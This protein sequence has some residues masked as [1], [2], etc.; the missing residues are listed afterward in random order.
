MGTAVV[1][2]VAASF[3]GAAGGYTAAYLTIGG[4]AVVLVLL[5]FGLKGR[6]AEMQTAAQTAAAGDG[7]SG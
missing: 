1:G 2:A 4:V 6:A 5:A 7:V 3:G